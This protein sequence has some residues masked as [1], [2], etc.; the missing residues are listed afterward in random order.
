MKARGMTRVAWLIGAIF[1]CL[2][3][4]GTSWAC[5]T[6]VYRYAL[7][8][9]TP[10]PYILCRIHEG[11][12]A[13]PSVAT[14]RE[15]VEQA[16]DDPSLPANIVWVDVDARD[17]E[18][19]QTLPDFV[20]QRWEQRDAGV[21]AA[22]YLVAP[23]G[24]I[25]DSHDWTPDEMASLLESSLRSKLGEAIESAKAGVVIL[26]DHPGKATANQEAAQVI[27]QTLGRIRKGELELATAP[28]VKRPDVAFF[29]LSKDDEAERWFIRQLLEI[30]S[31]LASVDEPIVFVVF[32][33]GRALFSCLGKGITEENLA[34]DVEFVSGACS[35]TVKEQNPGVDLLMR[36][37]WEN[38]A[39]VVAEQYGGETGADAL[40]D[41]DQLFPEL[42]IPSDS[43]DA[44][45]DGASGAEASSGDST[46]SEV[47]E[48]ST[49]GEE[50]E[51]TS[52]A[53]GDARGESENG[54][55][56]STEPATSG[57]EE[58]AAHESSSDG[59]LAA[60][61]TDVAGGGR[62][63]AASPRVG[64]WSVALGLAVALV[65][66]L[67]ATFLVLRPRGG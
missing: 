3:A 42:A 41:G 17:S 19:L 44:G 16:A 39:T 61:N 33:R 4:T 66:M 52:E 40:L 63:Q 15:V 25:L 29:R 6:P 26:L 7:Y 11:P 55:V 57:G 50:T 56:V 37:N 22:Y 59:A 62:D 8:R 35:C 18:Q 21:Q 64:L 43:K 65:G 27:E 58:P 31:D 48:T 53:T 46:A 14:V 34:R 2:A 20:R 5:D 49:S 28:S 51:E 60:R 23:H 47:V 30:E 54:S 1:G 24:V 32:G 9:W 10:T 45:S 38:A 36:Y 67:A 13:D 12:E